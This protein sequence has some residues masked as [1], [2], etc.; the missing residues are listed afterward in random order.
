MLTALKLLMS[1]VSLVVALGPTWLFLLVK[2]L[3]A[4]E[5]FWQN[6]VVYGLGLWFLAFFQIIFIVFWVWFVLQML[7]AP[8]LKKNWR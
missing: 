6:L 8:E 3:L 7:S 5:G 1:F 4:P 2:W